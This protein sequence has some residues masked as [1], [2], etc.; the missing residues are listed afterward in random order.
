MI[1]AME[2]ETIAKSSGGWASLGIGEI[3]VDSAA[4]ESCWPRGC[5]DAFAVRPSS[6]KLRLRAANG[7]EME[8]DSDK[9]ITFR[10]EGVDGVMGLNFQVT[11]V[12]KALVAVWRLVEHGNV[13]CFGPVAQDNYI[14]NVLR[15][16]KIPLYKR[17]GSYVMRVEFVKWVAGGPAA[18]EERVFQGQAR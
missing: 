7:A 18:G 8:H 2:G 4:D 16:Q 12:K 10:Q 1:C 5:G 6:K 13:V 15:K 14:M 3:T 9:E 17:G 11:E